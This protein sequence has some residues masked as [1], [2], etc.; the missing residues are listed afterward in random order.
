VVPQCA[1]GGGRHAG[2]LRPKN[3]NDSSR[4]Y[5]EQPLNRRPKEAICRRPLERRDCIPRPPYDLGDTH[6]RFIEHVPGGKS[7]RCFPRRPAVYA[8]DKKLKT[9]KSR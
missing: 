1:G 3:S 2:F 8:I 5:S 4:N 9:L 7:R 6:R